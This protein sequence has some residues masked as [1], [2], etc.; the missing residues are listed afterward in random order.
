MTIWQNFVTMAMMLVVLAIALVCA[1]SLDG[2]DR[3]L[4]YTVMIV[5]IS[6]G[7]YRAYRLT[8]RT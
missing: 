7:A 4:A 8:K 3:V 6:I 5:Y 2:R 1:Q